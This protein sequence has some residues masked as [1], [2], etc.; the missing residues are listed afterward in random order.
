VFLDIGLVDFI[1]KLDG[2]TLSLEVRNEKNTRNRNGFGFNG[3][4]DSDDW[5]L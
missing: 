5:L 1:R 2:L 3:C 4:I